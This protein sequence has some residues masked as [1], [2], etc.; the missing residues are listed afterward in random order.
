MTRKKINRLTSSKLKTSAY[1]EENE[2]GNHKDGENTA[3]Q[4]TGKELASRFD[5]KSYNWM[6]KGH[7]INSKQSKDLNRLLRNKCIWEF[8]GGP[9]VR[10]LHFHSRWQSSVPGRVTETLQAVKH[11]QK[12]PQT[13]K[14]EECIW[15]GNECSTSSVIWKMLITVHETPRQCLMIKIFLWLKF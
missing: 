7:V 9:V 1:C 2:K 4:I 11:G 12:N 3:K 14:N 15:M 13:N 5:R 10:A 8:P 6:I